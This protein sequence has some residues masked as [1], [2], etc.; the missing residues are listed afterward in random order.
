M[1]T[2]V[3]MFITHGDRPVFISP[4]APFLLIMYGFVDQR[5][6]IPGLGQLQPL[7]Y[8]LRKGH[9]LRLCRHA[10]ALCSVSLLGRRLAAIALH[11]EPLPEQEVRDSQR[12]ESMLLEDVRVQ[13]RVDRI[14]QSIEALQAYRRISRSTAFWHPLRQ[15]YT[16]HHRQLPQLPQ[17]RADCGDAP[18]LWLTGGTL[19]ACGPPGVGKRSAPVGQGRWRR[20]MAKRHS[21]PCLLWWLRC[22]VLRR[23]RPS[24]ATNSTPAAGTL[25]A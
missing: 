24:T 14:E 25:R 10:C 1:S 15:R 23:L 21:C 20:I 9:L 13:S 4:V 16:A 22:C 7:P 17:Q 11:K 3:I 8:H 19:S 5:R 12:E 18:R 6:P 2:P